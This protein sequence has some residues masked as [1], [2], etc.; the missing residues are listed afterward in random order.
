MMGEINNKQARKLNIMYVRPVMD[1]YGVSKVI[2]HLARAMKNL[3]HNVVV[4]AEYNDS[5]DK[6]FAENGIKMVNAPMD[7]DHKNL[8]TYVKSII[9][10]AK[11][12]RQ[13]DIDII[14]S[15][16]RWGTFICS[17]IA[18]VFRIPLITT[19]HGIHTGNEKLTVWGNRVIAVSNDA[20]KHLTAHFGLKSNN[21]IVIPNGMPDSEIGKDILQTTA[22]DLKQNTD[23]T[24]IVNIA[25]LSPEKDQESLLVAMSKV[26]RKHPGCQL[27]VVGGGPLK[28]HLMRTVDTLGLK[29]NVS[30]TGEVTDVRPY[31]EAADFSVLSS[32]TEGL[33]MV[34]LE[35]LACGKP[36]IAT[37]VGDIPT[38]LENG[39]TGL[40]V[41]PNDSEKLAEAI[42]S[43]IGERE[44]I[45]EMGRKGREHLV[46]NYGMASIA[47][48]TENVYYDLLHE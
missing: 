48:A 43:L 30:F 40:L 26:I 29:N 33:P 39:E 8:L 5:Y 3:G 47:T 2:M 46:R 41:P 24:R 37:A 13:Y 9:I 12:L 19:Y 11:A 45:L 15:H 7:P 36:V 25:R 31:L 22:C 34:V 6:V 10:I 17:I 27:I 4:V 21:I 16:H 32:L 23:V 1:A 14:H 44:T 38:V 20:K 35:S 42:C 18:K 28:N